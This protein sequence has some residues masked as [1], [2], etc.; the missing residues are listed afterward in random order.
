M[1]LNREV[2]LARWDKTQTVEQVV[3]IPFLCQIPYLRYLFGTV[4]R[5]TEKTRMYVTVTAT[6]LNTAAPEKVQLASG[7][8]K[9]IK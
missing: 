7:E 3:G 1:E 5:Q 6:M 2:I 8:L 9:R 4:T